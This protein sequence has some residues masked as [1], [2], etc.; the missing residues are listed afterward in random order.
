M[1]RGKRDDLCI[2]FETDVGHTEKIKRTNRRLAIAGAI[3]TMP[4][5]PI[6]PIIAAVK[7]SKKNFGEAFE[8]EKTPVN[9][10]EFSYEHIESFELILSWERDFGDKLTDGK[11]DAG[12]ARHLDL[13][14]QDL[15]FGLVYDTVA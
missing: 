12:G 11:C 15:E 7:G 6:V 4:F 8:F 2:C 5:G 1:A 3:L 10:L 13:V 9:D 14:Y